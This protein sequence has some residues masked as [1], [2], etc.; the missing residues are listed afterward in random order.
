MR[1]TT[2]GLIVFVMTL[3]ACGG[4][5]ADDSS[6]SPETLAT[7]PSWV[8]GPTTYDATPCGVA[9]D[10]TSLYVAGS[11]HAT[12]LGDAQWRIEK[13]TL[14]GAL[15]TTFGV[16]GAIRENLTTEDEGVCAMA[17]DADSLY[18]A[19]TLGGAG[20]GAWRIEKRS[21][22]TGALD[23]AFGSGGAI[24]SDPSGS[25]DAP[26]AIL[27]LNGSIYTAG[28]Q[29]SSAWRIEKRSAATGAF[30][31]GFGVL[32]AVVSDPSAGDDQ[33]MAMAT[34]GAALY[35]AGT[36]TS[37]D[38]GRSNLAWRVEKRSLADGALNG[39]F[40]TGGA[41]ATN[42]TT[43]DDTLTAI[44]VDAASVYM[45]GSDMGSAGGSAE[46]R[47]EKR[48]SVNGALDAG[49]GV[50][51]CDATA[52]DDRA[53]AIAVD[54]SSV[55]IAGFDMGASDGGSR[56]RLEKRSVVDGAKETTQTA[57]V[58]QAMAIAVDATTVTVAGTSR[59]DVN[60]AWQVMRGA[61]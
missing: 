54:G 42:P 6:S 31:G 38:A 1:A 55:H 44:A 15:D 53:V 22:T 28:S 11:D 36:T 56:W 26:H 41:I 47:I 50:V 17:M 46:W 10:A 58:G 12:G 7:P 2:I 33:A 24:T 4:G 48:S 52:G 25:D 19:G 27:V 39:A 57:V 61:K 29:G 34:D 30:D 37:V 5:A 21:R 59:A 40:G 20:Q 49:F 51:R 18:L 13:R 23:A 35:I 16:A 8:Q 45:A 3:G 32:G 14:D 9:V 60:L 43:G